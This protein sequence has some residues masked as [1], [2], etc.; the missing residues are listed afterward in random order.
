MLRSNDVVD[1]LPGGALLARW[2]IVDGHPRCLAGPY[3]IVDTPTD[4]LEAQRAA[5]AVVRAR[6]AA[7]E[8]YEEAKR[9]V[10]RGKGVDGYD[11]ATAT[12]S[13]ASELTHAYAH[14]R[15][16]R[17]QEPAPEEEPSPEWVAYQRACAVIALNDVQ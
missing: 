3:S 2:D 13:E 17:P 10:A 5:N 9:V 6:L 16:G 14:V 4:I 1:E 15:L 12:V 7:V 11:A 8:A